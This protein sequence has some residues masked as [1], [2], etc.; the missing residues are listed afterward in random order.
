MMVLQEM[1]PPNV[2]KTLQ[3]MQEALDLAK[4]AA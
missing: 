3:M 1:N 2:A 4:E